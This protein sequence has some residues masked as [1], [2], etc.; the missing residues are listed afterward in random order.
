MAWLDKYSQD[1]ENWAIDNRVIPGNVISIL[2]ACA[3]YPFGPVDDIAEARIKLAVNSLAQVSGADDP[4]QAA[5]RDWLESIG[6][7][8]IAD[9]G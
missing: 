7:I 5:I 8:A 2:R 6:F 9:E 3:T 4:D 1:A